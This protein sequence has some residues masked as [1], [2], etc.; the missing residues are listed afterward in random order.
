[1]KTAVII[2]DQTAIREMIAQTLLDPTKFDILCSTGDGQKGYEECIRHQPDFVILDVLLPRLNGTEI[3]RRLS[4][5]L[6]KTRTLVFSGYQNQALVSE[7]LQAGS[8]GIVEKSASFSELQK[9]IEIVS[10]GGSYFGPK[11]TGL[12]REAMADPQS[13]NSGMG[14]LTKREREVL[15][16][17]AESHSTKEISRKLEISVKTA[18]SHRTNLMRKLDLHDVASLTRFAIS[19]GLVPLCL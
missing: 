6:P 8:H 16:L 14:S 2:E 1:M 19:K 12:L 5:Q 7:L 11:V 18:E 15:L 17:I 13:S 9:G 3:V 10:N 4:I